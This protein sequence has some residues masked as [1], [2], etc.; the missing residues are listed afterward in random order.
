MLERGK[1]NVARF[2]S[3]V[4][5]LNWAQKESTPATYKFWKV[6]SN[7]TL[8]DFLTSILLQNIK[9][10]EGDTLETLK[11]FGKS[12]TVPKKTERGN[13]TVSSGFVYYAKKGMNDY[14]SVP[15]AK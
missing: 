10:T 12:L 4:C 3:Q 5:G 7:W 15:W 8:W 2:Q 9:K 11:F 13:S 14:I 6:G 1:R